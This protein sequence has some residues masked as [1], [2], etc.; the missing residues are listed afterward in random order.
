[1][2]EPAFVLVHRP[3]CALHPS[4]NALAAPVLYGDSFQSPTVER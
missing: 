3:K 2:R 1:M 4:A